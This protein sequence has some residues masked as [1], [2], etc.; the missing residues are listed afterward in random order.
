MSAASGNIPDADH[1]VNS[2]VG[3]AAI[4]PDEPTI[5]VSPSHETLIGA[6]RRYLATHPAAADTVEGIA[7]WA[8]GAVA[9]VT[10]DE[11]RTA[12]T[13]MEAR[14]EV[15][16]RR[17]AGGAEV[18][19]RTD[20]PADAHVGTVRIGI[21]L[22]GSKIEII[23]IDG[24]GRR[25]I[26]PARADAA[27]RLRRDPRTRRDA[28]CRCR[29]RMRHRA[30]RRALSASARRARCRARRACCAKSNR[31]CLNGQALQ[32]RPRSARSA[33]RCA[34][35]TTPIASRCRRRPT[36]RPRARGSCSAS[37]SARASA[38]ASSS[39]GA[40]SKAATAIAG[41]WGHN[42]L[43]WPRRRRACPGAAC[44]CGQHGCIETWLSGPG[45][46]RDHRAHGPASV[47]RRAADRR[48][49]RASTT[50]PAK[51]RS[52]ATKIASRARSRT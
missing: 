45:L 26:A 10:A 5:P 37:S 30:G 40:C 18:F 2:R 48:A 8:V 27:Q 6:I 14:G 41:E 52:P 42:P 24:D 3:P 21:D 47:A 35:R 9:S 11:V 44:Y 29:A 25:A 38:A 12:L 51:R 39:T 13:H 43:P 34:S 49:R 16:K 32:A 50:R 36:A 15:A 28:R 1:T 46:A 17:E 4:M 33:A 22:G 31:V 23:A 20:A 19:A 7:G